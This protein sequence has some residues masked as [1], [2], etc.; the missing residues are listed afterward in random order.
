MK[1]ERLILV[2]NDDGIDSKG[3][4]SLVEV[5]REFGRVVVA[6]PSEAMSGMS[7]AITIKTPLRVRKVYDDGKVTRYSCL[8]TPVDS[9]KLAFNS[10]MGRRPDLVLSGINHGSNSSASV[11]YS[12]TM[13]AAMEGCVNHVPS[14]GFS[15]LDY[16]PDAD[17]SYAQEIARNVIAEIIRNGLDDGV[18]LNVNIPAKPKEEIRGIK[19]CR[20]AKG[21][22]KEEFDKRT[23]PHR[24][25]YYWLTGSFF[26]VEPDSEDTDEFAL[27]NDYVS[28]VPIK[29]DLTDYQS[30]SKLNNWKLN[31]S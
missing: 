13:A 26:N 16:D 4:N 22:W 5:A 25:E 20:Q 9:V 21:Y 24:G 29:V 6:A 7:H 12:G 8:G 17:F 11:V 2:S 31:G 15:L 28:I 27:N 10:L 14:A 18:C 30:L 23:D 1:D 3:I 19:I